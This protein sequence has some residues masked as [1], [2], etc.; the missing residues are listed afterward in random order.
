MGLFFESHD[1]LIHTLLYGNLRF[2]LLSRYR[3]LEMAQYNFF[4]DQK[5]DIANDSNLFL[6]IQNDSYGAV[7]DC[8]LG[9]GLQSDWSMDPSYNNAHKF[10]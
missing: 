4:E 9:N 1:I 7:R 5:R 3:F 10:I 6:I 2:D 8:H